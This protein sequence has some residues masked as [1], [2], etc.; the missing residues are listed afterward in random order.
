MLGCLSELRAEVGLGV[1]LICAQVTQMTRPVF[2]DLRL[3]ETLRMSTHAL[4]K[5]KMPLVLT[6]E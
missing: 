1:A 6:L 4:G 3:D 5:L 2:L